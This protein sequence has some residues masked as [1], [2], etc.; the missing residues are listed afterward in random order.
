MAK[1]AIGCTKP[2]AGVI[3]TKPATAPEIPPVRSACHCESTPLPPIPRLRLRIGL[4]QKR[5]SPGSQRPAHSSYLL[6]TF[7]RARPG[8]VIMRT[9]AE[10]VN[11]HRS[12]ERRV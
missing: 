6:L 9:N 5:W 11:I 7:L 8:P 2:D 3:A 12:E 4:P 1:A 10:L